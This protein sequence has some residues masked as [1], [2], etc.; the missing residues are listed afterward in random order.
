[1]ITIEQ[2]KRLKSLGLQWNI[3]LGD[4]FFYKDDINRVENTF[5]LEV[6][7]GNHKIYGSSECVFIPTNEQ[8]MKIVSKYITVIY[9]SVDWQHFIASSFLFDI[10]KDTLSELMFE[11][12]E[13]VLDMYNH[14][15]IKG[16][17]NES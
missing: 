2:A 10:R 6:L 17:V 1:M 9:Y 3:K 14:G 11:V 15:L 16:V 4:Y 13:L 8:L 12:S 7:A 5:D